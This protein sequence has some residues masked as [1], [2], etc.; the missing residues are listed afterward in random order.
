MG[1]GGRAGA[2]EAA[3]QVDEVA[4][5]RAEQRPPGGVDGVELAGRRR[6]DALAEPHASI[7]ERLSK[8]RVWAALSAGKGSALAFVSRWDD[9]VSIDACMTN[10][11]YLVAGEAAERALINHVVQEALDEG[12]RCIRLQPGFQVDGDAFYEPCGFFPSGSSDSDWLEY[13]SADTDD[14]A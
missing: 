1:A 13:R 9:R 8:T 6:F 4:G 5:R 11:S 14:T 10:P 12:I 3:G 7:A 2:R